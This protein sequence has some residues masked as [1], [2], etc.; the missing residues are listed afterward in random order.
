MKKTETK[1]KEDLNS[2]MKITQK[3]YIIRIKIDTESW[4]K[5]KKSEKEIM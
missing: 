4:L 5:Q 2:S 1:I 3:G